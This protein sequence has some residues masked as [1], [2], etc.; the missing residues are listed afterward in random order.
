MCRAYEAEKAWAI[1]LEQ[2][3]R[4]E[5]KPIVCEFQAGYMKCTSSR[6]NERFFPAKGT[7][8]A[9]WG[10]VC[11]ECGTFYPRWPKS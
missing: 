7:Q 5:G 2:I 6:L 9:K 1:R 8:E 11:A 10:W 3:E 4:A